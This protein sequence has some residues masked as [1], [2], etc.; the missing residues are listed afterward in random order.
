[1]YYP[2]EHTEHATMAWGDCATQ[3]QVYIIIIIKTQGFLG[4]RLAPQGDQATGHIKTLE[5]SVENGRNCTPC[6]G[7]TGEVDWF[8]YY[9]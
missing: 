3:L 6:F 8:T 5:Q 1:M 9:A 4:S 2:T 7:I